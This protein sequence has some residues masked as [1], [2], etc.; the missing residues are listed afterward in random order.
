MSTRHLAG[1]DKWQRQGVQRDSVLPLLVRR[2]PGRAVLMLDSDESR[3]EP[4]VQE[5]I[6]G[7]GEWDEPR[8]LGLVPLNAAVDRV[9]RSIHSCWREPLAGLRDPTAAA[10]DDFLAARD[11]N[12]D[13]FRLP[14]ND[15]LMA[16]TPTH[17]GQPVDPAECEDELPPSDSRWLAASK[18]HTIP[19][20]V[21]TGGNVVVPFVACGIATARVGRVVVASSH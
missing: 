6:A 4:V 12:A 16:R 7:L 19:S 15:Y 21:P 2:P 11:P 14:L 20:E 8:R 13:D 17:I 18:S 1:E 5:A 10:V 9:A 3:D